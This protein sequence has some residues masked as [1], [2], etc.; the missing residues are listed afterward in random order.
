MKWTKQE[1][2][3]LLLNYSSLNRNDLQKLLPNRT[4]DAIQ[5]RGRRTFNMCRLDFKKQFGNQHV[6]GLKFPNRKSKKPKE[7][8]SY[9]SNRGYRYVKVKEFD[10]T[11]NGWEGYRPEHILIVEKALGRKLERTKNGKGE[12]IHHVDG[13]K[14]NNLIDNLILYKDEK[15]HR[16]IHNQLQELCFDLI[17]QGK[18]KFNKET[19]KYYYEE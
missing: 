7:N 1:D 2:D 15:E 18:I 13:N 14:L 17:K 16:E 4:W 6:K 9:I 19:K 8:C 10:E 11:S 3:I 12:G 5:L